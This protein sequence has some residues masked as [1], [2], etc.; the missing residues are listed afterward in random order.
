MAEAVIGLA[1]YLFG[2]GRWGKSMQAKGTPLGLVVVPL[3]ILFIRYF[4]QM[5]RVYTVGGAGTWTGWGQTRM[6]WG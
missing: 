1:L 4:P 5:G 6:L 2:L 3:S